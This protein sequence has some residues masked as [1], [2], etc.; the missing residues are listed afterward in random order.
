MLGPLARKFTAVEIMT[1]RSE[2]TASYNPKGKRKMAFTKKNSDYHVIVVGAGPGGLVTAVQLQKAGVR[3]TVLEKM[4]EDRLCGEV[5]GAYFIGGSVVRLLKELG[6]MEEVMA[7]EPMVHQIKFAY[8]SGQ[9]ARNLDFPKGQGVVTLR[10]SQLQRLLLTRLQRGALH[11]GDGVVRVLRDGQKTTAIL[12]SGR[13]VTGDVVIGADGIRSRVLREILPEEVTT[14]NSLGAVSYWGFFKVEDKDAWGVLRKRLPPGSLVSVK[15]GS[16]VVGCAFKSDGSG[17]WAVVNN[18]DEENSARD[19]PRDAAAMK[20][21]I[22]QVMKEAGVESPAC[23]Y[24][25]SITDPSTIGSTFL[26]DRDPLPTWYKD[27]VVV[28]GDAAHAMSPYSGQGVNTAMIDGFLIATMITKA[29]ARSPVNTIS[30]SALQALFQK[31]EDVRKAP[32]A[33]VVEKGRQAKRLMG[34]GKIVNWIYFATMKYFPAK[35]L[36]NLTFRGDRCNDPAVE[37]TDLATHTI[38]APVQ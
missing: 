36:I 26:S 31:F 16:V 32:V 18:V 19:R 29:L 27:H 9:V 10:R 15:A 22:M 8:G 20:A 38:L 24:A 12:E 17:Y 21:R 35:T 11:C 13:S 4:T 37:M 14:P 7:L 33:S 1:V 34:D 5:G 6:L 30:D 28:I 25:V 23:R 2:A 3:V